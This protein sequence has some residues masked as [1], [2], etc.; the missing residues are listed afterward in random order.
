MNEEI[1][2]YTEY[3]LNC[4]VK[5][6]SQKGCPLNNDIPAFIKNIK[7]E[8]YKQAYN[9]LSKTTVL[10]AIC[11]RICPHQKQCQGA[12]VR[13][14]KG[15]P[16]SIGDLEA[17]VGDIALEKNFEIEKEIDKN[18]ES[19]KVAV[20]GGGPAGLTAAA[21]LARKGMN[22][23]IY[24]KY[25]Y[26]GGILVHGIPDFRLSKNI[27]EKSIEKILNLGIG[28]KYN[29][30]I[31]KN[32]KLEE[33]K[34]EYDYI[35]LSCGANVSSK[36]GIEGEDLKGVFGGNELLEHNLH[37]DYR[38]KTVIVNG[39]GN[40]A[41]DTARTVKR[42]GAKKVIITYRRAIEQMPAEREEIKSA[43][44]D[45]IEFLCQRNIVKIYGNDKN[46]VSNIELIKTELVQTEQESRPRPIDIEGSNYQI[47]ADYVIMAIGSHTDDNIKTLGLELDDRGYIKVDENSKTSDSKVFAIGDLAKNKATVAWAARSGRDVAENIISNAKIRVPNKE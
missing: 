5:P 6:C 13:G 17:F 35:I 33:L 32:L 27:V 42:L 28:V 47:D 36:M 21:F 37:P 15:K 46:E 14:I 16:V 11:G 19:T 29:Q 3:C 31:G 26:L 38:G 18:L 39:G 8:N 43:M 34:Q 23:T 9:I 12:C 45:G 20:V 4:P 2:K 7:E 24:E 1:Q 44:A 30:E 41:M 22:V 40:V 25:N 10:S